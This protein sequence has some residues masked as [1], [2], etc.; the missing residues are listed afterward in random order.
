MVVNNTHSV[1]ISN[2]NYHNFQTNQVL[3]DKICEN[4]LGNIIGI[5]S[6]KSNEEFN[7]EWS[8][9]PSSSE[10]GSS[11]MLELFSSINDASVNMQPPVVANVCT[12]NHIHGQDKSCTIDNELIRPTDQSLSVT[13]FQLSN[14]STR[15]TTHDRY[16][17]NSSSRAEHTAS[18]SSASS[19]ILPGNVTHSITSGQSVISFKDKSKSEFLLELETP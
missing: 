11:S 10:T 18:H 12:D 1:L 16:E 5:C 19:S 13:G 14:S 7:I 6:Y 2:E 9:R 8:M 4:V 3:D 17:N 15:S